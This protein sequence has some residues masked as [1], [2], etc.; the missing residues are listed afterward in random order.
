MLCAR[1]L[2]RKTIKTELNNTLTY[3][4]ES[5]GSSL[6]MNS[7]RAR[8]HLLLGRRSHQSLAPHQH[9]SPAVANDLVIS[10]VDENSGIAMLTMN[11]PPANSLSMEM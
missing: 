3:S 7:L 11:R 1:T 9:P 10:T 6:A 4:P 2:L 8:A 5:V